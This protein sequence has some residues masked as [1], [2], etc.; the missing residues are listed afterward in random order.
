MR[1]HTVY[2]LII[3]V[4]YA[5]LLLA[6]D[7][8]G[9]A[10]KV[11]ESIVYVESKAGSCTGF[12]IN[13]GA[14]GDM[15]HILTAQHCDGEALFADYMT[16]RVVWKHAK[17]DLMVVEVADTGRPALKLAASNPK[18]GE[19]IASYGYGYALERPMFRIAHVS[20]DKAQ[21]PE[22]SGGPFVMIDAGYVSGQ[23]GGPCVNAAGEIV[24]IVQQASGLVG[25]GVGAETIR[26]K[27]GRYF[28]KPKP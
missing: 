3:F 22:V 26:D 28:E 14:K 16:A 7:W 9:T 1:R 20:D 19:E 18:I 11:S 5:S 23:S 13:S 24:S 10:K 2:T 15:D 21:L 4:L 8:T 6:S 25:I 12:V 17:S 27:A